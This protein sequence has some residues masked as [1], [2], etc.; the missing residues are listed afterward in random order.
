MLCFIG[1]LC[2]YKPPLQI[3]RE[4][5]LNS[6][7]FTDIELKFGL[8]EAESHPQHILQAQADHMHAKKKI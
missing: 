2:L 4:F 6:V 7:C 3:W 1:I 8:A 5:W